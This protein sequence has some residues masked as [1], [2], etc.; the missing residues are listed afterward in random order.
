[1][2][3]PKERLTVVARD[4]EFSKKLRTP[5]ARK[6]PFMLRD[7]FEDGPEAAADAAVPMTPVD[8]PPKASAPLAEVA[9]GAATTHPEPP[10]ATQPEQEQHPEMRRV[11]G[12]AAEGQGATSVIRVSF[13][14]SDD[15][16]QRAGRLARMAKCPP[17]RVLLVAFNELRETLLEKVA[18]IQE[19][20]I[21]DD[22]HADATGRVDTS[23]TIPLATR[24]IL[25]RRLDPAG[26]NGMNRLLSRWA[27]GEFTVFLDR[28]LTQ[29]GH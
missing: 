28:Y 12:V 18:A 5:P 19:G 11:S 23:L 8:N 9:S 21:P 16:M 14:V 26:F 29:K 17:K 27:R 25:E 20:D 10:S 4:P 7:T 2:A 13:R 3:A 15:L 22:R 1:M 24:A 6:S